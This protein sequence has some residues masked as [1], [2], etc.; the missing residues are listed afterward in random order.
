LRQGKRIGVSSNSHKAIENLLKEVGTIAGREEFVFAGAKVGTDGSAELKFTNPCIEV[1]ERNK[2]IK[3][4]DELQL[5][6]AT[7]WFFSDPALANQLDY[8]FIDE[9]GQVCLANVLAMGES[10]D[11][12]VLI[13]DQ[14][15]LDQPVKGSHPGESGTSSLEYLLA[16]SST[17]SPERGIFLSTTRRLHPEIC[18]LISSAVYDGRLH[19]NSDSIERRL[20]LPPAP[21]LI[22]AS[23]G[24]LFKA[25]NHSGNS[26]SS[27]EEVECIEKLI[28]ELTQCQLHFGEEQRPLTLQDIMIVAPYNS[29]VRLIRSRITSEF[30]GSVDKFQGGEKTVV[31]ISM[32]ASDL[33]NSPRGMEFLLSKK[34]LNV[35]ITRAQVLAII[36]GNRGLS[37][38]AC[39]TVEQAA[40]L[41]LYCRI[42]QEGSRHITE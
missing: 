31:I 3:A 2:A 21:S 30:I 40:L 5:I 4:L 20:I 14:L 15:Q 32:C 6:G 19:T 37:Q 9:A 34:R 13:G 11:N 29:Q 42:M 12:L 22:T 39:S 8:L 28:A 41:N 7:A 23:S 26:Q 17:I 1:M 33:A 38:F 36:V 27:I 16:E 25:V 35:A 24:I 18:A 10:T